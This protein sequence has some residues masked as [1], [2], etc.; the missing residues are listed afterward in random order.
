M[1]ATAVQRTVR[2]AAVNSATPVGADAAWTAVLRRDRTRDGAFV[3]AVGTTGVYCRPSCPSRRPRRVN[4]SFFSTPSDAER[5]GYRP[6]RR[7][8]PHSATGT[9]T[10]R[11]VA[12]AREYID[13]HGDAP[14]TLRHLAREVGLSPAYLQRVFTRLV[15]VSPK[16]YF[17]ARRRDR[18]KTQLRTG[19]SV[20]RATYAAGFGSP[21]T[22]YRRQGNTLG[23]TPGRYRRGGA[24]LTIT[25]GIVPCTLGRVLIARTDRG[26]CA[27]T[28]GDTDHELEQTL[29]DEFPAAHC[30]RDDAALAPWA[31]AVVRR[32]DGQDHLAT[33]PLDLQGT[34]FQ[35]QVW[36]ALQDIPAGETRSYRDVAAAIGRPSAVRA[37]ARACATNRVA[38]VVPCHR[39]IATSGAVSGYRWGVERKE[40]LLARERA[41]SR[42]PPIGG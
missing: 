21:S 27:V 14:V 28:L 12:A 32:V 16:A 5:S 34:T 35:M 8:R 40:R 33:I 36:R 30:V 18:L 2:S 42:K 38:V 11:S 1:G 20:T 4:V 17:D 41:P 37:V 13:Q 19:E 22:L 31:N 24:H 7:C 39:V 29:T 15:G 10:E 25:Y 3:Y 9:P 6:C 23:V 26:V